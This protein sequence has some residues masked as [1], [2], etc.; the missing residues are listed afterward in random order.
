MRASRSTCRSDIIE[1]VCSHGVRYADV[2]PHTR[3]AVSA[4]T[5]SLRR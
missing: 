4:T 2:Q 1:T 3:R 5:S